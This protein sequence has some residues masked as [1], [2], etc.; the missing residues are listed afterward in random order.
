MRG[1]KFDSCFARAKMVDRA[2]KRS[3]AIGP[4]N[5]DAGMSRRMGRVL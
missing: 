1:H 3:E 4:L 2:Q 5:H